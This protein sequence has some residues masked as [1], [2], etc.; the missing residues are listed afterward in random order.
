MDNTLTGEILRRVR[1]GLKHRPQSSLEPAECPT[2]GMSKALTHACL[3]QCSH[4][5]MPVTVFK[6]WFISYKV[7]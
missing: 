3:S 2:E 7:Y 6:C 4:L 5:H 1:A